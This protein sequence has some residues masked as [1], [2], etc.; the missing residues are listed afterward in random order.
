MA[1][2]RSNNTRP[3]RQVYSYQQPQ[4]ELQPRTNQSLAQRLAVSPQSL[5][6][7]RETKTAKEF[8]SWTRNRDPMSTGWEFSQKDGLYYPVK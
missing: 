2:G 5:I 4:V 1:S 8:I 7:E 6:T 3:Q